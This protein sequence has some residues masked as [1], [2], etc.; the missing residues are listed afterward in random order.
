MTSQSRNTSFIRPDRGSQT[1]P[2]SALSTAGFHGVMQQRVDQSWVHNIDEVKQRLLSL[3]QNR[4][5]R[6]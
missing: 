5:E 1:G 4:P 2:N 6:N 3:P